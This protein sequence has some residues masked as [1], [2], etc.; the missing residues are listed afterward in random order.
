[1]TRITPTS[2][3]END[4]SKRVDKTL[5]WL[6]QSRDSWKE[7]CVE[8]KLALKRQVQEYKRVIIRRDE[9]KLQNARLKYNLLEAR[10]Q[11]SLLER[12]IA[13]LESLLES[14]MGEQDIKK[15]R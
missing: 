1:M 5:L 9:L 7:K 6:V 14:K 2:S 12:R 11:N 13:E 3:L 4:L 10:R 8:A 15:K